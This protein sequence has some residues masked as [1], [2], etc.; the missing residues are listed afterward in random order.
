MAT[1]KLSWSYSST[2]SYSK[3]EEDKLRWKHYHEQEELYNKFAAVTGRNRKNTRY[4]E[5]KVCLDIKQSKEFAVFRVRQCGY[6]AFT[7]WD[8][9]CLIVLAVMLTCFFSF[10]LDRLC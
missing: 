4:K 7:I 5:A 6:A 2:A 8:I 3:L 1:S 10:L 9:L